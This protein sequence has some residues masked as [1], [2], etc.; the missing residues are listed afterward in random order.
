MVDVSLGFCLKLWYDPQMRKLPTMDI[1]TAEWSA[2]FGTNGWIV[3]VNVDHSLNRNIVVQSVGMVLTNGSIYT[4]PRATGI[5]IYQR[6]GPQ[7]PY[8]LR[9]LS[10]VIVIPITS[11]NP[12]VAPVEVQV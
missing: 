2:T 3:A 10:F 8:H 1:T 5:T 7:Q 12:S 6:L 9:C 4:L 11:P